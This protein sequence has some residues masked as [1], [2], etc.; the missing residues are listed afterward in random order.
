MYYLPIPKCSCALFPLLEND[1]IIHEVSTARNIGIILSI[2]FSY[3]SSNSSPS[4]LPQPHLIL[5][6]A[7]Y[8]HFW[9]CSLYNV[10]LCERSS[11]RLRMPPRMEIGISFLSWSFG[12]AADLFICQASTWAGQKPLERKRWQRTA[13]EQR[14]SILCAEHPLSSIKVCEFSTGQWASHSPRVWVKGLRKK[15]CVFCWGQELEDLEKIELELL[16]CT[17]RSTA[18]RKTEIGSLERCP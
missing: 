2:I 18:A 10:E 8:H 7:M 12:W 13:E 15:L 14:Q 9:R 11:R 6:Y 5:L 4:S 3:S 17:Q 16:K 1:V